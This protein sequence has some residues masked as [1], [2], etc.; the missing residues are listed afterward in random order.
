MPPYVLA[1]FQ[2]LF[3]A[4]VGYG[5]LRLIRARVLPASFVGAL[6][7]SVAT[8]FGL[9]WLAGA[10]LGADVAVFSCLLSGFLGVLAVHPRQGSPASL[11]QGG[12]LGLGLLGVMMATV[13][14]VMPATAALASGGLLLWLSVP[15]ADAWSTE[16]DGERAGV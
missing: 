6:T 12:A 11:L 10:V 9:L 2:C 5:A 1:L 8:T 15:S 13:D 4:G 3:L 16:G 7:L 14:Q